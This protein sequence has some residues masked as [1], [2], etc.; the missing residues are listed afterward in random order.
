MTKRKIVGI[1][2]LL[3]FIGGVSFYIYMRS[4]V[5]MEPE[6]PAFTEFEGYGDPQLSRLVFPLTID[7]KDIAKKLN[8][9]LEKNPIHISIPIDENRGMLEMDISF[10][11]HIKL[12]WSNSK[13]YAD[14]PVHTIATAT[15]TRL[16]IVLS[17]KKPVEAKALVSM[18][19]KPSLVKGWKIECDAILED[20]KWEQEP[21]FLL[22]KLSLNLT[23]QVEAKIDAEKD[24][25]E[26][27]VEAQINKALNLTDAIEKIWSDIQKPMAINRKGTPLWLS[28]T[29]HDLSACWNDQPSKNPSIIIAVEGYYRVIA[30]DSA[31]AT[32]PNTPLPAYKKLENTESGIDAYIVAQLPYDEMKQFTQS[33]TDTLRLGYAD[34]KLRIR[35]LDFFG[36]DSLLYIRLGIGGDVRGSVYLQGRPHF[37]GDGKTFV[38]DDF[39]YDLYTENELASTAEDWLHDYLLQKANEVL[40]FR[41]DSLLSKLPDAMMNGI[42]KSKVGDKIDLDMQELQVVPKEVRSAKDHLALNIH[43]TGKAA[44]VLE[45]SVLDGKK[46]QKKK[47]RKRSKT[48]N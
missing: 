22:G 20:I 18:L 24:K 21:T 2:L 29:G 19:V 41:L 30:G 38:V 26:K 27:V 9:T 44:L 15:T 48:Q 39:D 23:K 32:T 33:I 12:R 31:K 13:L 47:E 46:D 43:V 36:G 28:M 1:T 14:V 11:D 4:K 5:K 25:I 37:V 45:K 42:E 34:Y 17:N 7:I 40:V 6:P 35:N 16:G 3:L 8:E 10:Y